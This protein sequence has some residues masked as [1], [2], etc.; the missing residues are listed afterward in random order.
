MNWV[1][2]LCLVTAGLL[3]SS[4]VVYSAASPNFPLL[5]D[6]DIPLPVAPPPCYSV[7]V[8]LAPQEICATEL[9]TLNATY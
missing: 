2:L 7:P 6:R 9:P 8:L 1:L 4:V 5:V 3:P